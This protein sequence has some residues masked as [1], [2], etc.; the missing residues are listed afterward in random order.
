M[1]FRLCR[2]FLLVFVPT[3]LG[4]CSNDDSNTSDSQQVRFIGE[5]VLSSLQEFEGTTVG[6]LSSIEYYDG[7]Y[8]VI[9]DDGIVE[10]DD[11]EG[12]LR[13]YTMELQLNENSF[14]SV[15]LTGVIELRNEN[16]VAFGPGEAD[17]EALRI[18]K[19]RKKIIWTSEGS[20]KNGVDPRVREAELDGTFYRSF[21]NK[22]RY[23]ASN[24][25]GRGPRHNATFEGLSLAHSGNGYW[26]VTEGPLKQDGPAPTFEDTQ[27]P[28]RAAHIDS[29]SGE[30]GREFAI[31]LDPVA[32]QPGESGYQ[33]SVNGIVEILEYQKDLFLVLERSFASNHQDGGNDIKLYKVDATKATDISTIDALKSADYTPATKELLFD[34]ESIRG[35]LTNNIVDNIEGMTLGPVFDDGSQALVFVSD[36]NFTI[37]G[38]QLTQI[39]ALAIRL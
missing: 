30:F 16:D 21:T 11:V 27:S 35:E 26:V 15:K 19:K 4:A 29:E 31:E 6:G 38:P 3:I 39:I 37:Y 10:N 13:V 2:L 5:R 33:L 28:V 9:S 32:R 14:E 24:D 17:P 34:F 36:D 20:I 12:G 18:D 22:S 7:Q 1:F 25:E 8:Y 23:N